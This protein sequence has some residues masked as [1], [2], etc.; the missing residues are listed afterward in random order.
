[1]CTKNNGF[2]LGKEVFGKV[3]NVTKLIYE[4]KFEPC[5]PLGTK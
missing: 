2:V 1:M 4:Q 5:T 3:L